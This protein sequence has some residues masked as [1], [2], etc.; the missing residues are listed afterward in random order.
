MTVRARFRSPAWPTYE[1]WI[2]VSATVEIPD[3]VCSTSGAEFATRD[4]AKTVIPAVFAA[5]I[6]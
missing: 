1:T 3:G 2:Q 5:S 6:T 4:D